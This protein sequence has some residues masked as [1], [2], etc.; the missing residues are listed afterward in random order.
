MT[1]AETEVRWLSTPSPVFFPSASPT[2]K[3]YSTPNKKPPTPVNWQQQQHQPQ[4]EEQCTEESLRHRFDMSLEPSKLP[5]ILCPILPT[6]SLDNEDDEIKTDSLLSSDV[7]DS[8]AILSTDDNLEEFQSTSRLSTSGNPTASENRSLDP[9]GS[10]DCQSISQQTKIKSQILA[11][12]TA[13]TDHSRVSQSDQKQP[14]RS[15]TVK[16]SPKQWMARLKKL[17]G[18]TFQH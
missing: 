6:T 12:P 17:S 11:P 7:L 4:H 2:P 14:K 8:S 13:V 9:S 16:H 10:V 1:I 5:S 3:L 15:A 18:K